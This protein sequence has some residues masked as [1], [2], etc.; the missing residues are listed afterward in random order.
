MPQSRQGS[1]HRPV[2][3]Y[4]IAKQASVSPSTVSR[5]LHKPGRI[6]IETEERIRKVAD[7]LGYR[8]N[9]LARSL[10]TGRTS[11]IALL[12]SDVTNPVFFDLIRGASKVLRETGRT[13]VLAESQDNP[14]NELD[15]AERL[16]PAVDG[17][18]LVSS[19]MTDDQIAQLAQRRALVVVHRQVPG[20][21]SL[22]ADL[23][24][25]VAA[26]VQHLADL[27]H[28]HVLYLAGPG[29]SWANARRWE[30]IDEA[31]GRSGITVERTEEAFRPTVDGGRTAAEH[32]LDAGA[33]AVVAFNDL[34]AIG[35]VQVCRERGISVPEQLSIIGFDDIFGA[36]FVQPALTTIATPMDQVGELGARMLLARASGDEADEPTI[37]STLIV[38]ASTAPPRAQG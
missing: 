19:R 16:V 2:T 25:G 34:M 7:E 23:T 30:L 11:T 27:G 29:T 3:I 22:T 31:C 13:L 14:D 33:T 18:L 26:A 35:V 20:V 38:R 37:A 4:D 10:L 32:V 36:D 15:N 21:P 24:E 12:V 6:N 8:I 5:A 9:P 17:I 28:A 1:V